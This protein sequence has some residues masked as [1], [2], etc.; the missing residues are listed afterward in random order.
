MTNLK[1]VFKIRIRLSKVV[2]FTDADEVKRNAYTN[3]V[4]QAEQ[5]LNK[6][7]GPNTAK[8]GVETGH[9]KMYNVLKTI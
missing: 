8:D 5:I 2:N 7:Q 3:A 9:Y 4:T 1:M 6:A